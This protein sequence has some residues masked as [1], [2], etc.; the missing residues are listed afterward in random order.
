MRLKGIDTIEKANEFVK[1]YLNEFN[2]EFALPYNHTIDA[3][4]KQINHETINET[5]AILNCL[6]LRL[7]DYRKFPLFGLELPRY[8]FSRAIL[9]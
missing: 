5:L 7:F 4:E 6:P 8:S 1:S 2:D 9:L 3:F